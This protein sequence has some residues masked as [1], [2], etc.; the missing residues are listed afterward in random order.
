[1]RF[2]IS[3]KHIYSIQEMSLLCGVNVIEMHSFETGN[4]LHNI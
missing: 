4:K 2:L 3:E 1:M